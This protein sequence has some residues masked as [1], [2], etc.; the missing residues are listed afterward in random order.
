MA[1]LKDGY[2]ETEIGVIPNNWDVKELSELVSIKSGYSPSNF[3]LCDEG[4][5]PFFKVDDMNYTN[6]YLVKAKVF[7]NESSYELMK[8]GMVVFPKRG[9]SIFT[10]KVAILDSD[11]FFDTNIMG[12]TVNDKIN[13]EFLYYTLKY[14]GL[15]QFADTTAV[16]QINNKHI[17]PLRICIPPISEQKSIVKILSLTDEHIEKL[18][19]IIE[20]YKLLKKGMMKKLL[21]EGIGHSEFKDTEVG[22]IPKEWELVRQGDVSVFYNGRAYKQEEFRDYGTP[23]IRIQNLTGEGR[24][25]YTDL[26]LEQEKYINKGD[27][28]YAWSATFGPYIWD[29]VTGIY[30]YHIWKIIC[31]EKI[32]KYFFYYRLHQISNELSNKKNGSVFAHI[33]KSFMEKHTI[34]LPSISEQKQIAQILRGIDIRIDLYIQEKEDFVHLKK[35]LMEQLLTGKVRVN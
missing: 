4:K 10:N 21:T 19:K 20:D 7:F 9:A 33:T 23:I 22:R 31:S 24:Y 8:A 32:D 14:I 6:K 13:N 26:Q 30:H 17:N 16:P 2:K 11:G 18:N 29:G 5:F 28:I 27:L 3:T 34:A 15:Q 35:G 12:L 1:R 25:V